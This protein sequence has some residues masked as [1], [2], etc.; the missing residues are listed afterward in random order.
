[1]TI[2]K[3][4]LMQ[5]PFGDL[6]RLADLVEGVARERD[7]ERRAAYA[8]ALDKLQAEF[9]VTGRMPVRRKRK[10]KKERAA[11]TPAENGAAH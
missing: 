9:G 1:M 8:D 3:P 4:T 11:D 6:K 2:D 7:G 5:M 10:L